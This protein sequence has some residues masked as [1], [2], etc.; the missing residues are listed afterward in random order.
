MIIKPI[1]IILILI[2]LAGTESDTRDKYATRNA[3]VSLALQ[4]PSKGTKDFH[5]DKRDIFASVRSSLLQQTQ[6]PLRL[7]GFLPDDGDKD[8]PIHAILESASQRG[9]DIQLAWEEDCTGG[10]YCHYGYVQG[11]LDPLV[12]NDGK[13]VPVILKGGIKGHFIPFTCGAHCDDATIGWSENGYHYSIGLKAGKIKTM[14]RVA[15]SAIVANHRAQACPSPKFKMHRYLEVLEV[16]PGHGMFRIH[17]A[18]RPCA[19]EGIVK[20]PLGC[21]PSLSPVLADGLGNSQ[22]TLRKVDCAG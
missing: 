7:P 18:F 1:L 14:I 12:E 20:T 4:E 11:S 6:V 21:G 17:S 3:V 8:W 2:K 10:N 13:R 5:A 22:E 15:N 19:G 16:T 9:Y